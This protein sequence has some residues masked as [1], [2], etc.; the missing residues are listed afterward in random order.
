M[1]KLD[2]KRERERGAGTGMLSIEEKGRVRDR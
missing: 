2:G 1:P